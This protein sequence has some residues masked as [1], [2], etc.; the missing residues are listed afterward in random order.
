MAIQTIRVGSVAGLTYE[1]GDFASAIETDQTIRCGAP[2]AGNEALRLDDVGTSVGNVTA[3]AVIADHAIVRGAGGALGIQDSGITIDDSDN[4][5]LPDNSWIGLGAAAGRIEFDDQA[6]DEINFLNCR[7]GI[8]TQTPTYLLHLYAAAIPTL[9]IEDTTNSLQLMLQ[10]DDT[11]AKFGLVSAHALDIVTTNTNRIKISDVGVVDIGGATHYTSFTAAGIISL[12]GN[13]RV[14]RHIRVGAGS[15][16]LGA[17]GPTA[18]MLSVFPALYF[19]DASDDEVH[20]EIIAPFRMEAG[21]TI[22]VII[23]WC[24][25]TALDTGTVTW[26]LEFNCVALGENVAG[27]TTT[28]AA[29]SAASVVDEL[30]R[31]TLVT[32]ITG[33]V[34][35]DIIGMR[36]Y[37]DVGTGTLTGDAIL[38][39][40]HFEVLMDKL[41]EPI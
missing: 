21:S 5:T 33:A 16:K 13:A 12:H 1:D 30:Q 14:Y 15:W 20:Y 6:P 27:A 29:T 18:A 40:V 34:A 35:H 28:I 41:G 38:L 19:D 31:T 8:G 4:I 3:A 7:V 36:L 39:D 37:R 17:S 11:R 10:G 9:M 25:Q 2:V 24:H 32:G 26:K 23:D 22:N